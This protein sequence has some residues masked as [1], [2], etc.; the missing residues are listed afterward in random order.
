M[1]FGLIPVCDRSDVVLQR[2]VTPFA[3]PAERLDLH[4]QILVKA[5][6]VGQMEPVHPE[7]LL[8]LIKSGFKI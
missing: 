2:Q 8:G 4:M 5:D 3:A 6:R 7:A 1:R